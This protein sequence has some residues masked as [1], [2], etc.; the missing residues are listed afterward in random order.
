MS[1]RISICDEYFGDIFSGHHA[2]CT[3]LWASAAVEA[4]ALSTVG[5][6][7]A[8]DWLCDRYSLVTRSWSTSAV[9]SPVTRT[10]RVE[11]PTRTLHAYRT[12]CWNASPPCIPHSPTPR[13]QHTRT[14]ARYCGSTRE[15]SSTCCR[16]RLTA[17][18]MWRVKRNSALWIYCCCWWSTGSDLHLLRYD[19]DAIL[20]GT[21][22]TLPMPTEFLFL[23]P[24]PLTF[25]P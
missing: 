20:T 13:S 22:I 14:S 5:H 19:N 8:V 1:V 18:W 7:I 24:R 9:A 25:E 11:S 12:T 17:P 21:R 10:H 3:W 4:Q 16:W 23:W 15:S 2:C 6:Y